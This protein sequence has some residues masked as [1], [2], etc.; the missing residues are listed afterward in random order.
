MKVE[1]SMFFSIHSSAMW[2]APGQVDW[3]RWEFGVL[4]LTPV[5]PYMMKRGGLGNQ[6]PLTWLTNLTK[7]L[8]REVVSG[9]H[10]LT[11]IFSS[12]LHG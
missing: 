9:F 1:K 8:V 10:T 2:V 11:C 12:V 7:A 6:W 4:S 5:F 3:L